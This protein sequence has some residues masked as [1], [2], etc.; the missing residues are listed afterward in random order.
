[1]P[2]YEEGQ[3]GGKCK[4]PIRFLEVFV[5]SHDGSAADLQWPDLLEIAIATKGLAGCDGG[6]LGLMFDTNMMH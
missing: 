4:L 2:W 3:R 5:A 1:M 6:L